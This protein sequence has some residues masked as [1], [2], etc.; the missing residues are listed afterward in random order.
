[1]LLEGNSNL[2]KLSADNIIILSVSSDE[3]T[4]LN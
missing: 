1:M 2:A 3:F 4:C